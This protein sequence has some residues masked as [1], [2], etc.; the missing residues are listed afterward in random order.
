M[1]NVNSATWITAILGSLM[2]IIGVESIYRNS[3]TIAGA[4]FVSIGIANIL[5]AVAYRNPSQIGIR[6]KLSYVAGVATLIGFVLFGI[7]FFRH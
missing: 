4:S 2:I 7:D 6:T 1:D 3:D 5:I